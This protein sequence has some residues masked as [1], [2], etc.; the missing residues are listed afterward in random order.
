M[1]QAVSP[2]KKYSGSTFRLEHETGVWGDA[3]TLEYA[4]TGGNDRFLGAD[5]GPGYSA[6]GDAYEMTG[7]SKGG[8]D[9]FVAGARVGLGSRDVSASFLIPGGVSYVGDAYAMSGS[10][11]GGNDSFLGG[12][13]SLNQFYGDAYQMWDQARGGNDTLQGGVTLAAEEEEATG[14]NLLLGDAYALGG[15]ARG[16]ADTVNG[17]ATAVHSFGSATSIMYG[18]GDAF[19]MQGL[20]VGGADRVTGGNAVADA[21]AAATVINLLTG[22]AF[23]LLGGTGGADI[24]TGGNAAGHEDSYGV[25]LVQY[26]LGDSLIAADTAMFGNDQLTGGAGAGDAYV[27]NL[28]LGDALQVADIGSDA[29]LTV[30]S[31]LGAGVAGFMDLAASIASADAGIAVTVETVFGNDILKGGATQAVNLMVGDAAALLAGHRGGNDVLTG[32]GAGTIN[33]M[34]GD[35]VQMGEGSYGGRDRL[36][37]GAGTD[38]MYGDASDSYGMGGADTFVFRAGNG[39]D[40]IVDFQVGVDKIDVTALKNAPFFRS[41]T[42]FASQRLE[43]TEGGVVIHLEVGNPASDNNTVLL[44]GVSLEEL[45]AGSFIFG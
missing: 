30:E 32:G 3:Y 41:F 40:V 29:A 2:T 42:T 24:V 37:S 4:Q 9:Q 25:Q 17:G 26:L 19:L 28:I 22:D 31:V 21:Y 35:A 5:D 33:L 10:S 12:L 8:N 16:G 44:A 38:I 14:I 7:R 27:T 13:N 15:M 18:V 20:S 6:L 11:L 34:Y 43:Q 1:G 45:A 23:Y 39:N 36:I